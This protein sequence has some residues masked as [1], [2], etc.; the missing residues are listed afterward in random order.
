MPIRLK[1]NDENDNVKNEE[2]L[3]EEA[4]REELGLGT[5]ESTSRYPQDSDLE[6]LH[7]YKSNPVTIKKVEGIS[8]DK[9]NLVYKIIGIILVLLIF[10]GLYK[11]AMYM[12]SFGG[13]DITEDLALSEESL[14]GL[15][16]I[17]FQ[18]NNEL[19]SKVPQ[20]S[21]GKVSV[22]SGGGLNV[23]YIDGKQVGISTT[24]RSY[25]FYGVAVNQPEKDAEEDMTY[26]E[27]DVMV[28][29]NDLMGGNSNSYYHYN[30][31][32]NDCL[33]ITVSGQTS[34]VVSMTYFTDYKKISHNLST[35]DD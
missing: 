6:G 9:R 20:Y 17:T 10:Y 35:S 8:R 5:Y 19:A 1:E 34:R 18:D 28:V 31:K 3:R 26:D 16:N 14:A 22:R 15:Y 32:N 12:T 33:V 13:R 27:D 2:Q 29:L 24:S 21:G 30:K 4:A 7:T 25:K 11:G 23:I